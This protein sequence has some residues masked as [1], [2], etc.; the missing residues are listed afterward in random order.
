M[1]QYHTKISGTKIHNEFYECRF[2]DMQFDESEYNSS[3]IEGQCPHCK[4]D[5]IVLLTQYTVYQCV[6][7]TDPEDAVETA[8]HMGKWQPIEGKLIIQEE[9]RTK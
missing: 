3:M 5:Q 4:S 8:F 9:G 2:C 6:M 7:A 1:T